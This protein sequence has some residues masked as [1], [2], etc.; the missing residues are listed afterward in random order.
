MVKLLPECLNNENN[1]TERAIF[2]GKIRKRKSLFYEATSVFGIV[3]SLTGKGT[4]S[5]L[6]KCRQQDKEVEAKVI[7]TISNITRLFALQILARKW[8]CR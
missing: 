5:M 2:G 4:A 8:M 6:L 1:K 7:P 3:I